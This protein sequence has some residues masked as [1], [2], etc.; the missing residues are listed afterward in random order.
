MEYPKH[1]MGWSIFVF[2]NYMAKFLTFDEFM[3]RKIVF[4]LANSAHPNE[5]PNYVAYHAEIQRQLSGGG[6][7]PISKTFFF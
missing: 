6:G 5:M 4:N 2:K 3:S 7:G 1:I